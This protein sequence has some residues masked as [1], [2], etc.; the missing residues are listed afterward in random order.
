MGE[1]LLV[2]H[3]QDDAKE[4]PAQ[5]FLAAE[6]RRF[7]GRGEPAG[8]AACHAVRCSRL[9]EKF[10]FP[11]ALP[12]LSLPSPFPSVTEVPFLFRSLPLSFLLRSLPLPLPFRSSSGPSGRDPPSS[13]PFL[14]RSLPFGGSSPRSACCM[15]NIV[16]PGPRGETMRSGPALSRN[17]WP[18]AC[19]E[20]EGGRR[21]RDH[22]TQ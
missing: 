22:F 16:S 12:S 6:V 15:P 17:S 5:R 18:R 10:L 13:V 20:E 1:S 14:S 8:P 7:C 9:E 21:R 4:T 2:D 19:D 11:L 3:H